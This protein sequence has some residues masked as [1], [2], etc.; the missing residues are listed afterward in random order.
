MDFTV[1]LLEL[2]WKKNLQDISFV[3][4]VVSVSGLAIED[5]F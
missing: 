3:A 2:S 4:G 5:T 1:D